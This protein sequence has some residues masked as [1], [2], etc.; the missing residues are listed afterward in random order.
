MPLPGLDKPVSASQGLETQLEELE[1]AEPMVARSF[2]AAEK[3]KLSPSARIWL[4]LFK[5][6][7]PALQTYLD[8]PLSPRPV[9]PVK[10]VQ[11][12]PPAP[13]PA[14][15][16]LDQVATEPKRPEFHSSKRPCSMTD[17]DGLQTIQPEVADGPPKARSRD[18]PRGISLDCQS[19][20]S[21]SESKEAFKVTVPAGYPGVQYRKSK[22]ME[23]KHNRYARTG[24]VVEGVVEQEGWKQW[25]RIG[26]NVY[27]PMQAGDFTVLQPASPEEAAKAQ[28]QREKP[29]EAQDDYPWLAMFTCGASET[30]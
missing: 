19:L 6:S 21:H 13:A 29:R 7:L 9:E 30:S 17:S 5:A 15:V 3:L 27:L 23:D 26:S 12:E 22:D 1:A 8:A 28:A 10:V 24:E 25:L 2:A 11:Q 4:E 20:R 14:A 18:A 16:E